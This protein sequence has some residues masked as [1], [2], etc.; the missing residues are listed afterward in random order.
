MPEVERGVY[1]CVRREG[2]EVRE[3]TEGGQEADRFIA[4]TL[5]ELERLLWGVVSRGVVLLLKSYIFVSFHYSNAVHVVSCKAG[6]E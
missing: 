3:G 5:E 2:V 1:A 6:S 4:D